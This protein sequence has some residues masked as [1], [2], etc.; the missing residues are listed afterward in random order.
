MFKFLEKAKSKV[1][2]LVLTA[3]SCIML[4]FPAFAAEEIDTAMTTALG[5]VKTDMLSVISVVAPVGVA[6]MGVVLVWRKGLSFFK[7]ITGR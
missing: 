4:S 1:S 2:L 3:M 5:T 6:I 7:S